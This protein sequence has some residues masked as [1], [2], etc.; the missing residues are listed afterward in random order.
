MRHVGW[1]AAIRPAQRDTM[2]HVGW[3]EAIRL[4][5]TG[6]MRHISWLEASRY[7]NNFVFGNVCDQRL[8]NATT[9]L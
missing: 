2:R 8:H 4:N 7:D 9:S 6:T 1:L 5:Q 3:L